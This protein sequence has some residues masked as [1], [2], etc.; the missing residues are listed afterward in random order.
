MPGNWTVESF[1]AWNSVFD[2]FLASE[3]LFLVLWE[4]E[5]GWRV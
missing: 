3:R 2:A 5:W 1:V 4:D